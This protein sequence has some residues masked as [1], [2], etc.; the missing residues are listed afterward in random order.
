[1]NLLQAKKEKGNIVSTFESDYQELIKYIQKDA[2]FL[3][4][5]D[6]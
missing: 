6:Y 1:M 4:I 2:P 5:G 3:M